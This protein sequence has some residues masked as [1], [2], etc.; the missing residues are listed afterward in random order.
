[1]IET[2]L[3]GKIIKGKQLKIKTDGV[4]HIKDN[5]IYLKDK[6]LEDVNPIPYLCAKLHIGIF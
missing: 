2:I 3:I 4:N 5:S 1:M 6:E